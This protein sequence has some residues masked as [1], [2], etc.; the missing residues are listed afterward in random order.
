[1]L[2]YSEIAVMKT[3]S[4]GGMLEMRLLK[5]VIIIYS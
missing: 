4:V 1:M 5:F 3:F 2:S